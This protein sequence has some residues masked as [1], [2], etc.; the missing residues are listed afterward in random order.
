MDQLNLKELLKILE[1]AQS[2]RGMSRQSSTIPLATNSAE[3]SLGN[4]LEPR[5][6]QGHKA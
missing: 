6:S 3:R 4:G 1:S 2:V 5:Q